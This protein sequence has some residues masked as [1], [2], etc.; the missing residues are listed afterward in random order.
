MNQ[1]CPRPPDYSIDWPA[2]EQLIDRE[3]MAATPQGPEYHAEGDVW[4][5]TVMVCESLVG[6]AGWRA[7]APEARALVFAAALLH[8]LGKPATTRSEPGGRITS[9]GHSGRGE[10]LP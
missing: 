7:L 1:I 5:H 4:T 2:I 6:L 8:D 9:R 10:A 3:V